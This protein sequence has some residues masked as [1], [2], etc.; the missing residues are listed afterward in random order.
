MNFIRWTL[1]L[2][3]IAC[4]TPTKCQSFDFRLKMADSLFAQKQY[5][6]SLELYR[7]I[8]KENAYSPAMLLKMA[9]VEEGLGQRAMSL[10]YLSVYYRRTGNERALDKM[11]E[12]ALAFGLEGYQ[13]S[14]NARFL[15]LLRKYKLAIVASLAMG[16]LVFAVGIVVT[17]QKALSSFMV[18][19]QA[20]FCAGLLY[21]VNLEDI[22][23]MGIVSHNPVY[24]MSA[25]SSGSDVVAIIGD[26]HRLAMKG[27]QDIWVKV[28]WRGTVAYVRQNQLIEIN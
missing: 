21:F 27:K 26:G 23:Q 11:E 1:L 14:P 16:I 9:Y 20:V 12:T 13:V 8:Y 3:L 25:P 22:G 6:Q 18:V 17:R 7:Q 19:I 28:N 15:L 10:Y 5:T 24:L 2:I 4:S